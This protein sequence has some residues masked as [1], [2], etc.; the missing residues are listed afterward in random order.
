MS[1]LKICKRWVLKK[2]K[3]IRAYTRLRHHELNYE[4]T[5]YR[6]KIGKYR[7]VKRISR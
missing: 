7:A 4:K 2:F 5:V 6:R 1:K 3:L